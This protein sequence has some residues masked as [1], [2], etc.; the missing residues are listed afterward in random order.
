MFEKIYF[1]GIKGVG[2]ATLAVIAKQAGIDIAG[3]DIAEQ[4]ITDK[5][6]NDEGIKVLEGF[7]EE[8]VKSF[9][10]DTPKELCLFI[11]TGAHNGFDNVEAE[12]ARNIGVKVIDHGE[13]V[14]FFMSGKPFGR[15]DFEGISVSG[16]HGK[17]TVSGMIATILSEANLDPSY[18]IGTSVIFPIGAAGHYGQGRYFVAEADEYVAEAN[19]D[20]VPKFFYQK[21][22]AL[23]INNVDFDHPDYYHDLAAVKNAYLDWASRLTNGFIVAN[24][25]DVNTQ[26][27]ISKL[28]PNIRVVRF[29][30]DKTNDFVVTDFVQEGLGST[31]AVYRGD[32]KLGDFK[33]SI[34][35][36]HSAKNA[37]GVIAAL[38]ELGVGVDKIS[39]NL[40]KFTGVKRRL[41]KIGVTK[42][43]VEIYDDYAHH[44]EE[45]RK[46]LEAVRVAFPDKKVTV[47][48]QAHTFSRTKALLP[49]FAASFTNIHELIILPTFAS[50]RDGA[51]HT[52]EDDKEFVEKVRL[53]QANVKLIEK[54]QDVVEYVRK[55]LT[56][57]SSLVITMGAGNVYKIGYD[58]IANSE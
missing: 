48:F 28:D 32:T 54:P 26:D 7:N 9:F 15:E 38:V 41:E 44:P 57:P 11:A 8:N 21:P 39:A 19:Y 4:F 42:D 45:I 24:G 22:K 56:D 31:F 1:M 3:S 35:G 49:E 58:L 29:G 25:D 50:L 13:A 16:S 52:V 51:D 5:I 47:I 14:G 37:C 36:Y 18:T 40:P 10:A 34:P 27:V 20:K 17:T 55:N 46:T 6:L 30:T 53:T 33:I 12:Y 2:M 43:G 23:L